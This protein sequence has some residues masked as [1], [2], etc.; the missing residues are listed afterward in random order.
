MAVQQ[1]KTRNDRYAMANGVIHHAFEAD[2]G[3]KKC[4]AYSLADDDQPSLLPAC[5]YFDSKQSF[6]V[7]KVIG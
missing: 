1:L 2:A 7:Q 4:A 3:C 5:D 6:S